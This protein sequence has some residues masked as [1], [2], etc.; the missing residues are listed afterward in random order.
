QVLLARRNASDKDLDESSPDHLGASLDLAEAG[1]TPAAPARSKSA[2][3]AAQVVP[4]ALTTKQPVPQ[5]EA[6]TAPP[7]AKAGESAQPTLPSS[8]TVVLEVEEG[9]ISV[10]SFLGKNMRAALE[11][12]QDAGLDLAAV[13]SGV[14]KEQSPEPGTKVAAGSRVVVRFGR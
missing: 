2:A 14:A 9:G 7:Q 6:T 4:A 5:T 8:G 3:I 13:G 12:A 10:P 11:A 1:E